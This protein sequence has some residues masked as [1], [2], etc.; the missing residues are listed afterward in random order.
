MVGRYVRVF[1]MEQEKGV[2]FGYAARLQTVGVIKGV[3]FS[4]WRLLSPIKSNYML[5][6]QPSRFHSKSTLNPTARIFNRNK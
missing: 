4:H 3:L 5:P 2:L 6:F 1:G